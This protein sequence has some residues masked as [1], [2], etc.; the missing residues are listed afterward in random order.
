MKRFITTLFLSIFL[1][2]VSLSRGEEPY[3]KIPNEMLEAIAAKAGGKPVI[4]GDPSQGLLRYL[5]PEPAR[6][7]IFICAKGVTRPLYSQPG[8]ISFENA[9]A[10]LRTLIDW[11]ERPAGLNEEPW[12]EKDNNGNPID[13][14]E[15]M[16]RIDLKSLSVEKSN[17]GYRDVYLSK[18][19]GHEKHDPAKCHNLKIK[20]VSPQPNT[21]ISGIQTVR[22]ELDKQFRGYSDEAG[23]GFRIHLNHSPQY[24]K[25]ILAEGTDTF[26]WQ[27]DTTT[28]PDG[29]QLLTVN[30]CDHNDHVG[31]DTIKV[32]IQNEE[33]AQ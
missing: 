7:R 28:V 32:N 10:V 2:I 27:W 3:P 22:V 6:V 25:E 33:A 11:E 26:T 12:D 15:Y 4:I 18:L 8:K 16:I 9:P 14:D 31:V 17:P 23:N 20:I 5:L 24:I 19:Y 13:S 30:V 29:E 21:T 1:I